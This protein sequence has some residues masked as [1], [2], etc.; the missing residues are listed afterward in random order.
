MVSPS[1]E[2]DVPAEALARQA[3]PA[4][5]A[6]LY[7]FFV[8]SIALSRREVD[9]GFVDDLTE[10]ELVIAKQLLRR[11]LKLNYTHLIAGCATLD[12]RDSIRPLKFMYASERDLSRRLTIA[13]ALWRIDRDPVFVECVYQ[14]V[15]SESEILKEAH[16][17]QVLCLGD[18]RSIDLLIALLGDAGGFVRHLALSKLNSIECR[19]LCFFCP[20][21]E[22]PHS[23]SDYT[24]RRNNVDFKAMMVRNLSEWYNPKCVYRTKKWRDSTDASPPP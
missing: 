15:Q 14:M 13:E 8:N 7:H 22:L 5:E 24:A 23:A 2:Y 21:D 6:F 19:N 20:L 10:Q 4:F 11:N 9:L 1:P 16:I 17:Q 18:E 3:S 12:D